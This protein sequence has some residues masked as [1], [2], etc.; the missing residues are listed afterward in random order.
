ML[1]IEHE[2][3]GKVYT[4]GGRLVNLFLSMTSWLMVTFILVASWIKKIQLTGY[5]SKPV[6]PE[7]K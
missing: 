7:K 1:R 6:K 3:E 5:W 2:A 4:K